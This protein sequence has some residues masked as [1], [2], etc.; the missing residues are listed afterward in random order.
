MQQI[1]GATVA[2][3]APVDLIIADYRFGDGTTGLDAIEAL[4]GVGPFS[5]LTD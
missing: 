3:D 2:G 5:L 4:G 1:H